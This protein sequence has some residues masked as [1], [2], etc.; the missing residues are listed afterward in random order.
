MMKC[1]NCETE[2]VDDAHYCSNCGAEVV[3]ERLTGKKIWHNLTNQFFGWDNKYILTSKELLLRP[4]KVL[5]PYFEG[6]RKKYVAPFA[7]L[8]I[9]TAVSMLIFNQ[10][11]DEYMRMVE[12]IND[13][14]YNFLE[15]RY[16]T[17][18]QLEALKEQRASQLEMNKQIQAWIL[19]YF[20]IL[21]F[22][23]VPVYAWISKL[24]FGKPFNYGEH[25]VTTAYF[26]GFLFIISIILFLG[27]VFINPALFSLSMVIGVVYYLYAY[28]RLYHLS[29]GQ[30]IIAFLKFVGVMI[31][32]TLAMG[33]LGIAFVLV[34][35]LLG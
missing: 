21:T 23:L 15:S 20:N 31:A 24:V 6:T 11:S 8:A 33:L 5:L 18:E 32:F 10:F 7:F 29:S 3:K 2:I 27:S 22:I 12:M 17:P 1:K 34:Q 4:E 35:R 16:T 14:E 26:Q 19:K 9:G 30:L 13:T 25:L 28:K